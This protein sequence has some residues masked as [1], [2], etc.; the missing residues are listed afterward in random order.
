MEAMRGY[1]SYSI[2]G[3]E[4]Q[5]RVYVASVKKGIAE[6]HEAKSKCLLSILGSIPLL[7]KGLAVCHPS[8]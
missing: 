4:I 1:T 5:S 3:K 6:S 7:D 2:N 8:G